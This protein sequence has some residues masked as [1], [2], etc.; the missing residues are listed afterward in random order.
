MALSDLKRAVESLKKAEDGPAGSPSRLVARR[1]LSGFLVGLYETAQELIYN[2][3]YGRAVQVLS[4]GTA[5]R[6]ESQGLFLELAKA[7]SGLN[8]KDKAIEAL[9]KAV[10]NGLDGPNSARAIED[11]P[12]FGAL[13]GDPEYQR[14]IDG[15]KKGGERG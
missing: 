5:V 13:K 9:K 12:D 4:V 10:S 6:P 3:S 15:M 7:Y 8:Q 14:I 1:V 2:H 11:D